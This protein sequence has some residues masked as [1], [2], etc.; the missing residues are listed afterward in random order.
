VLN[1]I[2]INGGECQ[3]ILHSDIEV[4]FDAIWTA[5]EHSPYIVV[6][7]NITFTRSCSRCITASKQTLCKANNWNFA[8]PRE[9]YCLCNWKATVSIC[10][11]WMTSASCSRNLY[12]FSFPPHDLLELRLFY[13]CAEHGVWQGMSRRML[14]FYVIKAATLGD[15][16]KGTHTTLP[17]KHYYDRFAFLSPPRHMSVWHLKSGNHRVK[18]SNSLFTN[19]PKRWCYIFCNANSVVK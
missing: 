17:W 5:T 6:I 7:T 13:Y 3:V 15:T 19:H 2:P 16:I 10:A 4:L 11:K 18:L 12:C 9:T 8:L 14:A 1:D